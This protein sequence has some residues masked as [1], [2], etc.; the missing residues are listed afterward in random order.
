M[1]NLPNPQTNADRYIYIV[2]SNVRTVAEESIKA[3]T[4]EALFDGSW[5]K[6]GSSLRIPVHQP[7]AL[8]QV[9]F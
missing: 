4:R 2:G 5:Q 3:A 6:E 1:L 8:T 9:K 7:L